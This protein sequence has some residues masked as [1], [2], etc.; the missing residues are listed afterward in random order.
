MKNKLLLI[1]GTNLI[2]WLRHYCRLRCHPQRRQRHAAA[3]E[4]A[5]EAAVA[6]AVATEEAAAAIVAALAPTFWLD[7]LPLAPLLF[8]ARIYAMTLK[9]VALVVEFAM[10]LKAVA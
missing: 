7:P 10:T 8:F 3:V 5:K 1:V 4:V 9:S 2:W 6:A